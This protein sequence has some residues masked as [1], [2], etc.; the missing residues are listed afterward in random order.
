MGHG[1]PP[2]KAQRWR[3]Q[4][5]S[6]QRGPPAAAAALWLGFHTPLMVNK[7]LTAQ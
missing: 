7:T 4:D 6:K 5:A 2:Y 3:P 1:T